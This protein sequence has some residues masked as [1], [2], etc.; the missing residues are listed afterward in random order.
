MVDGTTSLELK[1][2]QLVPSRGLGQPSLDRAVGPLALSILDAMPGL[3]ALRDANGRLR[4][5][6]NAMAEFVGVD[7]SELLGRRWLESTTGAGEGS[8][9]SLPEGERLESG[10]AVIERQLSLS[11][12]LGRQRKFDVSHRLL[13]ES[14]AAGTHIL[15]IATERTEEYADAIAES[16]DIRR[17]LNES[18]ESTREFVRAREELDEI[19]RR[20]PAAVVRWTLDD[21]GE[22]LEDVSLGVELLTGHDRADIISE[23]ELLF[24][25]TDRD[26][27]AA[28]RSGIDKSR[29]DLSPFLLE[30]PVRRGDSDER[31][32]LRLSAVPRP[33]T[34]GEILLDGV[35]TDVTELK[36]NQR[37]IFAGRNQLHSV[38]SAV[39]GTVYQVRFSLDG[40]ERAYLFV[41]DGCRQLFG[42][43]P[44]D[45]MRRGLL[46][47]D[48][49]LAG[50]SEGLNESLERSIHALAPWEREFRIIDRRGETKWVHAFATPGEAV[51]DT[52]SFSGVITDTTER[53]RTEARQAREASAALE[54]SQRQLRD[55]T[56]TFPGAVFQCVAGDRLELTYISEGARALFGVGPNDLTGPL[57]K[58]LAFRRNGAGAESARRLLALSRDLSPWQEEFEIL[59]VDGGQRWLQ[60]SARAVRGA[61]GITYYHG[62]LSDATDAKVAEARLADREQRLELALENGRLGLIDW[63]IQ[64]GRVIYNAELAKMLGY[65]YDEIGTN[66]DRL[67]ALEHPEDASRKRKELEAHLNG[68][69]EEFHCEYRLRSKTGR[70]RWVSAMG[71]IVEREENGGPLRFVGTVQDVTERIDAE[72]RLEQQVVFSRLITKI[73]SDFGNL[74]SDEIDGALSEALQTIGRFAGAQHSYLCECGDGE[75]IVVSSSVRESYATWSTK[76]DC[77]SPGW[78]WMRQR[79]A[80]R[81]LVQ[82]ADV[83]DLPDE[84]VGEMEDFLRRGVRSFLSVPLF[85][86]DESL[87]WLGFEFAES[88]ARWDEGELSLFRVVGEIIS[89]AV[90]RRRGERALEAAEAQVH[91]ITRAVPGVVAQ[92]CLSPEGNVE[93]RYLSGTGVSKRTLETALTDPHVLLDR[94]DE[95]DRSKLAHSLVVAARDLTP[96]QLDYRT[97]NRSGEIVWVAACAY[98]TR[99]PDGGTLFNGIA[100]DVTDRKRV[101]EALQASEERFRDLFESA[102]VMMHRTDARGQI[103]SVNREWLNALGYTRDEVLGRHTEEFLTSA[104]RRRLN[105][106]IKNLYSS[107]GDGMQDAECQ[108]MRRDGELVDVLLSARSECQK[109]EFVGISMS[110]VDVTERNQALRALKESEERYRAV[111]QDQTDVIC[112]FDRRGALQ[113]VNDAGVRLLGGPDKDVIGR[114][115]YDFIDPVYRERLRTRLGELA[116]DKLLH[117]Q[118]LRM[119]E[120]NNRWYQWTVRGSFSERGGLIGYQAVGRDIQELKVLET[121][122]REISHREQKRIGHD[123]HDGLG[124]E[125]TGVSLMLKTLE[126]AITNQV[127]ELRTKVRAV[128]DMVHQSIATTRALA[129]GLSPV[130]LERDGFAGALSQLTASTQSVYGIP[131]RFSAVRAM[132]VIDPSVAT[133]LYRIAQEALNNAARHSGAREIVVRFSIDNNALQLEV[134]DDGRG[135]QADAAEDGGMGLKI[136]RYRASMIDASLDIMPRKGGGTIIRCTLQQTPQRSGIS[137]GKQRNE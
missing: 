57:E 109:G 53:H 11:D 130:H 114:S 80:G 4:F 64:T 73:S 17:T 89:Q 21:Q 38:T 47:E 29:R 48:S 3:V 27:R 84:A 66:I 93:F 87:G 28:F 131:V 15:S 78:V 75:C 115:W 103:V 46:F 23:P 6:N 9:L 49:V 16:V 76:S 69:K 25:G 104:S 117:Q 5:V 127:P 95:R 82:V 50:D 40:R 13:E 122:I 123:L 102:P 55:I 74:K 71:R 79:I 72:R 43:E 118:E 1:S 132:T 135:I 33:V 22:R 52:V 20:V 63:Y 60:I 108:L 39:P 70:W 113:F 134:T 85:I 119:A 101:E 98:P 106:D 107:A 86:G 133:D 112:R 35:L 62:V 105:A 100:L 91:E 124:Q 137:Q 97:R 68:E 56:E 36:Q 77:A 126:Q 59:T 26:S 14:A 110:I 42:T 54:S 24:S 65:D 34:D 41:S 31:C 12:A 120:P 83:R 10:L 116:P 8:T 96:W 18:A 90:S 128:R 92:A 32:W 58:L 121:E 81:K 94:V 61:D 88:S 2:A 45:C 7:R 111:V 125:L 37:A 136:M 30:F 44:Q 99:M 129:Q 19:G 51:G 67:F